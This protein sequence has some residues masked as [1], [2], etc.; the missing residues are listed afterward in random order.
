MIADGP[1]GQPRDP[2]RPPAPLPGYEPQG[3]Y[4]AEGRRLPGRMRWAVAGAAVGGVLTL[5]VLV[6]L[7]LDLGTSAVLVASV[8]ALVPLAILVLAI[9]WIDRW[10]PEPRAALAF[11]FFWGGGVAVVAA[12]VLNTSAL[13]WM[14]SRGVDWGVAGGVTIVVVAPVVEETAKG[15]G[16]LVIFLVW[17]RH[18]DGPVD[19]LVYAATVATGFAVVEDVAYFADA[20]AA[21]GSA[22]SGEVALVFALRALLSPFAH[23]L[24]TACIGLALGWAATGRRP[25]PAVLAV[26]GGWVAAV[27][28]HA[29][30]N[31]STFVAVLFFVQFLALQ[32]PL[33]AGAIWLVW[34][35]RKREGL[36]VAEGLAPYAAAGWFSAH[37]LQMLSTLRN[38]AK[39]LDWAKERAGPAGEQVVR[40]FQEAATELAY[41]RHRMLHGRAGIHGAADKQDYL[42][43]AG[44]AR[45]RVIEVLGV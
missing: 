3:L 10:E 20:I 39:A 38:R 6:Y 15:L 32:V 24:F 42:E 16:V 12:L 21:S 11:A 27:V 13:S 45:A 36:A 2:G 17:R 25:L 41:Q 33:F 26:L 5:G 14:G 1:A 43:R 35:L 40:E 28:L 19:G 44:A 29:L 8:M 7:A 31:F 22:T 37:D 4:L 23:L 30:W 9:R 34:W 18:F